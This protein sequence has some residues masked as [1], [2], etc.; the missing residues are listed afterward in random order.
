[1]SDHKDWLETLGPKEKNMS[2]EINTGDGCSAKESPPPVKFK[3]IPTL[4]GVQAKLPTRGTPLAVGLD[5]YAAHKVCI[6]PGE[7]EMIGT[8]LLIE[9]PEGYE[10]QVRS[11]SGLAAKHQVVV[12]NCPGTIDPDYRGE[13]KVILKNHGD[14]DFWVEPGDRIAQLVIAP[15]T[16]STA[17]EVEELS[18][19]P[20]RGDAGFG[21]TGTR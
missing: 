19:A 9:V 15:V 10:G 5:I 8:G 20:T 1:M 13:L 16:Y 7:K 14:Y 6:G 11:R 18:P 17:V 12:L 4:S 2:E 21:S 3:R